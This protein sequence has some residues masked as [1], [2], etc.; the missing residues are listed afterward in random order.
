MPQVTLVDSPG[1]ADGVVVVDVSNLA[2]RMAFAHQ[3]LTTSAKKPSG[4]I[5]GSIRSIVA[6]LRNDLD[7]GAWCL[8]FCY[9]GKRARAVRQAISP[10]YKAN[11]EDG[12][13]DPRPD[14]RD[15]L[16]NVPGL[17]VDNPDREGDDGIVWM[18]EKSSRSGKKVVVWTG[19]RD[20]WQLMRH[21]GISVLSPNLGRYARPDDIKAGYHVS[22]PA[23]IPMVK[24]LFGDS[25]DNIKGW[26]ACRHKGGACINAGHAVV[27]PLLDF[28]GV[29]DVP[30]FYAAW[31][32]AS[33]A[34]EFVLPKAKAAKLAAHR[35]A[36]EINWKIIQPMVDGFDWSCVWKT[37][38]CAEAR[39]ALE[40]RLSVY[41][42]FS[43]L[44][45]LDDLFG[46]TE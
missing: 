4:H 35:E 5:Y 44:P 39:A 34:G 1:A 37:E 14:V 12:R 43:L 17:H 33:G 24:A 18:A 20:L 45:M 27:E 26:S 9:D 13:F 41:E 25:S 19:D 28:P 30:S 8:I 31:E 7:E 3:S 11:R 2:F 29:D 40:R 15:T 21:P 36:A 22:D 42:C 23:K 46:R 10:A 6:L 16:W 32:R 38:T